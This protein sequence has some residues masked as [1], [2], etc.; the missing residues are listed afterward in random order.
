MAVGQELKLWYN[1]RRSGLTDGQLVYALCFSLC[2]VLLYLLYHSVFLLSLSYLNTLRVWQDLA[3]DG[4]SDC[5]DSVIPSPGTFSLYQ[6]LEAC[7]GL[8]FSSP[9]VYVIL[10]FSQ[11]DSTP[12]TGVFIVIFH[13]VACYNP[14]QR[15]D[16]HWYV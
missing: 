7:Q 5:L 12:E 3:H 1:P 2:S 11:V 9:K 13:F 14:S 8:F 15:L 4:H 6:S 10:F 16:H